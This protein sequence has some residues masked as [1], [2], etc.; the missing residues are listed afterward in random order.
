MLIDMTAMQIW[1]S[2]AASASASIRS[3]AAGS[4]GGGRNGCARLAYTRA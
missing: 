1:V 2:E 3:M 4:A